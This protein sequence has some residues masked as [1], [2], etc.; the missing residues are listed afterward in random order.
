MARGFRLSVPSYH[1]IWSLALAE[2]GAY[3]ARQ[4][5]MGEE[6]VLNM[7]ESDRARD[8]SRNGQRADLLPDLE[9]W[10]QGWRA[11]SLARSERL[12]SGAAA[13]SVCSL[14]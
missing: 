4:W 1:I 5:R 7:G 9:G 12:V 11:G 10:L 8:R 13:E 14:E 6:E 2:E 3:T